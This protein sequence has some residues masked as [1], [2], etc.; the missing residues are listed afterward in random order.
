M[1]EFKYQ[2]NELQ[3]KW[4]DDLKTTMEQQTR[5]YLHRTDSKYGFCC[6]GRACVVA[7]W[8]VVSADFRD[9]VTY[10]ISEEDSNYEGMPNSLVKELKLHNS[11]GGML[12][13]SMIHEDGTAIK[14]LT[15][16]N[17]KLEWTF[18]QIAEYIEANPDNVFT[19]YEE[20]K[21]AWE[22]SQK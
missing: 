21:T 6:L 20:Q 1:S 15:L 4:L 16:L 13:P 8:P 19:D 5:F 7:N 10:G 2:Y 22:G 17:D 11:N 12:N 18:R 14:T 9:V 3:R